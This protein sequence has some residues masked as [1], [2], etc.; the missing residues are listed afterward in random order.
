MDATV[1]NRVPIHLA[2]DN[3][4]FQDTYQ[5]L[6]LHGYTKVFEKMLSHPKIHLLL[7]TDYK[8]VV[9]IDTQNY[10]STLFGRDFLG[11]IFYT[12]K[13]DELYN[14]RFGDLPYRSL[15][16]VHKNSNQKFFQQVATVNYPNNYDF[17]RITE[18]KR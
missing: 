17:T 2:S 6:P 8:E 3:R 12:G 18:F 13:I 10:K 1:T 9:N 7:N 15:K 11:K 5:G 14:Y 4:Y 16:F